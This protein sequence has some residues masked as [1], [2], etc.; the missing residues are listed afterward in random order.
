MRTFLANVAA[1]LGLILG[2]CVSCLCCFNVHAAGTQPENK[3]AGHYSHDCAGKSGNTSHSNRE[4]QTSDSSEDC[5]KDCGTLAPIK[6]LAILT[7]EQVKRGTSDLSKHKFKKSLPKTTHLSLN[8]HTRG[9][10][11]SRGAS[12]MET[13]YF[14]ATPNKPESVRLKAIGIRGPPLAIG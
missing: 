5:C 13:R 1:L 6:K 2:P 14:G 7:G 9:T 12:Q 3:I 8:L 4:G 10:F 11:D